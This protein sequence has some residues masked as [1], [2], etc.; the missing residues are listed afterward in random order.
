MSLEN[1]RFTRLTFP[2]RTIFHVIAGLM[3]CLSITSC[4]GTAPSALDPPELNDRI[5][6]I[7]SLVVLP[8]Q[9]N[10]TEIS[11]GGIIQVMHEWNEQA[12]RKLHAALIQEFKNRQGITPIHLAEPESGPLEANIRETRALMIAIESALLD[13]S[14]PT[15][16]NGRYKQSVLPSDRRSNRLPPRRMPF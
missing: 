8:P 5:R 10:M 11:T 6:T 2:A 3:I 4:G 9:I 12:E 14:L 13:H 7:K 1:Y 16:V 15:P